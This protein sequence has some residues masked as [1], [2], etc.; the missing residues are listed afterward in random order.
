MGIDTII[1]N[2]RKIFIM[3][4]SEAKADIVHKVVEGPVTS[5]A[6]ASYLQNHPNTL[7]LLDH[8]SAAKLTRFAC[9]WK[10]KGIKKATFL[11]FDEHLKKK[12]SFGL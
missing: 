8:A 10:I 5:E 6:P 11:T 2:S 1:S 12:V 7:F 9:P 3:A 4:S